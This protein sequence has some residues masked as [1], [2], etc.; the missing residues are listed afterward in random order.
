M[1]Q[2]TV[3]HA[4]CNAVFPLFV[5]TLM[6]PRARLVDHGVGELLAPHHQHPIVIR[7]NNSDSHVS[8]DHGKLE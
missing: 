5:F 7:W 3:A 4:K 8:Y 2:F 1:A 6:S